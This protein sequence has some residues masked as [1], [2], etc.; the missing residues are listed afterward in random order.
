M[1]VHQLQCTALVR[2]LI[3]VKPVLAGRIWKDMGKD[4][5]NPCGRIWEISILSAQF[6]YKPKNA[7]ENKVY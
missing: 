4:M 3:V 1:R 7:L 2:I 5:G 6:C